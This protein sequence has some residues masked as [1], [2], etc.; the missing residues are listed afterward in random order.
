MDDETQMVIMTSYPL[1]PRHRHLTYFKNK[2]TLN[3]LLL[4]SVFYLSLYM[5]IDHRC[6]RNH[7]YIIFIL[8]W[9]DGRD[10][11]KFKECLS[12]TRSKNQRK[13]LGSYQGPCDLKRIYSTL[14]YKSFHTLVYRWVNQL[15]I[16]YSGWH[17]GRET[18]TSSSLLIRRK[19]KSFSRMRSRLQELKLGGL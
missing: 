6:P 9:T 4:L 12:L 15:F 8:T 2:R 18:V 17:T 5:F 14:T 13:G 11:L 7:Y 1:R 10:D 16:N 19:H 3:I